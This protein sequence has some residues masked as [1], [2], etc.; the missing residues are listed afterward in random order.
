LFRGIA[1]GTPAVLEETLAVARRLGLV[2][3]FVDRLNDVDRPEDLVHLAGLTL[4]TWDRASSGRASA[5]RAAVSVIIPTLNEEQNILP[6]LERVVTTHDVE[7]IVVDGGSTDRTQELARSVGAR[8]LQALRGRASQMN[9]GAAAASGEV[10]VFLHADTLLPEGWADLILAE[11]TKRRAAAAAFEIQFSSHT[12]ALR[13]I[14]K[15]A[16]LRSHLFRMPYGDQTI[17]LRAKLFHDLGGF[18]DLP[19][20]EDWD[21][22]KRLRK[23]GRIRIA[24]APV[25]TSSRRWDTFGVL[26]T[27]ALNQVIILGYVLGIAPSRLARLYDRNVV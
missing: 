11:L 16:N 26:R 4:E 25:V 18:R 24:T 6:C 20:M 2:V 15:L 23:R 10:L 19:I 21:L 27:T 17:A 5:A 7:T 3:R 13:A 8:V 14:E 22:V 1:W 9:A 12:R